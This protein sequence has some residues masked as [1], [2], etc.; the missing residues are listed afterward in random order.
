MASYHAIAAVSATLEGVL[1]NRRPPDLLGVSIDVVQLGDFH[2]PR[3]VDEGISILLFRVAVGNLPRTLHGRLSPEGRTRL[4]SLPV[5]LYYLFTPWARTA[6]MQLRM[7]GWLMRTM[8]DISTFGSSE[9]NHYGGP[10]HVFEDD[11]TVS[12]IPEP[13]ALQDLTNLWEA[14]KPNASVSVAYAARY[15]QLDTLLEPEVGERVQV[16]EF[17]FARGPV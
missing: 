5:D 4:P 3:P 6:A 11:E 1:S 8:E 10:E 9:L 17:Q 2:K 13:L 15:V 16:R 14:L 7:L 12:L